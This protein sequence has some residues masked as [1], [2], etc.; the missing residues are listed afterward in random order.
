MLNFLTTVQPDW[1]PYGLG[2]CWAVVEE[3][4]NRQFGLFGL[5][6]EV[7]CTGELRSFQPKVDSPDLVSP[8]LKSIHLLTYNTLRHGDHVVV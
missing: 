3:L 7:Q 1:L 5:D 6:L 2:W 4:Y 8:G